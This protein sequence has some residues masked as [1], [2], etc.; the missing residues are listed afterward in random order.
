M[1]TFAAV[2]ALSFALAGVAHAQE[3]EKLSLVIS[4]LVGTDRSVGLSAGLHTDVGRLSY[5]VT[6]IGTGGDTRWAGALLDGRF[7][8]LSSDFSPYLGLGLGAFSMRTAALDLGMRL[9]ASAEAG[10]EYRRFFAGV[11]ALLPM[12]SR[13]AGPASHDQSGWADSALFLQAGFRL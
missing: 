2:A 11:R 8:L 13:S 4:P 10:L 6:A 5:G 3:T 7:S 9:T 1:R 12:S